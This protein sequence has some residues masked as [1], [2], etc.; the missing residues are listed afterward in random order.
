MLDILDS[1]HPINYKYVWS[2]ATEI[3]IPQPQKSTHKLQTILQA[4]CS[5]SFTSPGPQKGEEN[6]TYVH[7]TDTTTAI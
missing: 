4:S 5:E 6:V 3:L 2:T 7:I 1:I